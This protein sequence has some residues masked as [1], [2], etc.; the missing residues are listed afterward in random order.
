MVVTNALGQHVRLLHLLTAG[1]LLISWR[2]NWQRYYAYAGL[3]LFLFVCITFVHNMYLLDNF[4]LFSPT[5]D[6]TYYNSLLPF[7]IVGM[8]NKINCNLSA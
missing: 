7:V 5:F 1:T 2:G 6:I 3:M 4:N 8:V